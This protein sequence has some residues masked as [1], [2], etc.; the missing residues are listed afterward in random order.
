MVQYPVTVENLK[1]KEREAQELVKRKAM[2][3]S[4][5]SVLPIPLLDIGTDMKLMNDIHGDIEDVFEINHKDVASAND[6][7]M[8]RGWVMATSIGSD[9]VRSR[10]TPFLFRRI[11]KK[12]KFSRFGL[13]SIVGRVLGAAVSY[14]LM[15]KLGNDHI[16][17]CMAYLKEETV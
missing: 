15:K 3:S 2:I 16:E 11:S 14:F 8:T 1:S 12:N 4:V 5:A 6:D 10:L 17:H 7:L 13:V 9:I